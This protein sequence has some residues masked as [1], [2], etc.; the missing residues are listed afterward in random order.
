LRRISPQQPVFERCA[1]E[2]PDDGVHLFGVRGVDESE[3]LRF[4]C[5]GVANHFDCVGYQGFGT[6][7]ALDIVRC[8]PDGQI[9]KKDGKTHSGV[10]FNSMGRGFASRSFHRSILMLPH[11]FHA[12]NGI[13]APESEWEGA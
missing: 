10:I 4:L 6:E 9:S 5:F 3:A 8:D 1:I 2:A 13:R 12:V 11:S 7:P